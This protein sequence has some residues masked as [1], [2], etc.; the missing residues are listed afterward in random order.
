[1][2]SSYANYEA[3][4]I[5]MDHYGKM[6]GEV[7]PYVDI[8]ESLI[9]FQTFKIWVCNNKNGFLAGPAGDS[10]TSFGFKEVLKRVQRDHCDVFSHL[11]V[12]AGIASVLP[13]TSVECE[14]GFSRQNVIKTKLRSRLNAESLD[15]LLRVSLEGPELA[16]FSHTSAYAIWCDMKEG[17]GRSVFTKCFEQMIRDRNAGDT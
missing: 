14:R 1:M 6:K 7:E 11:A 16:D 4:D 5:L 2:L 3:F 17:N 15:H 10:Q 13:L 12:L 9:Q 8:A